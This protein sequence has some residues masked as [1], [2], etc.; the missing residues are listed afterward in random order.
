[1]KE[2]ESD[3]LDKETNYQAKILQTPPQTISIGYKASHKGAIWT[4]LT[5]YNQLVILDTI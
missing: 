3:N 4:I 5:Q 2:V 1:M